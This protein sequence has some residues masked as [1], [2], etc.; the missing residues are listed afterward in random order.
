MARK[1]RLT[2]RLS[3]KRRSPTR[4]RRSKR[5]SSKQRVPG[6]PGRVGFRL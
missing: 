3:A 4:R 6:S 2:R 1:R 5:R